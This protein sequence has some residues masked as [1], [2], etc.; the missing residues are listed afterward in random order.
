MLSL[1]RSSLLPP[2]VLSKH[3][4]TI[5][6]SLNKWWKPSTSLFCSHEINS[7]ELTLV[8]ESC[9]TQVNFQQVFSFGRLHYIVFLSLSLSIHCAF[10]EVIN[11][12]LRG[13]GYDS[14]NVSPTNDTPSR[15]TTWLIHWCALDLFYSL[16]QKSYI[17]HDLRFASSLWC[18]ITS[19]TRLKQNTQQSVTSLCSAGTFIFSGEIGSPFW[20]GLGCFCGCVLSTNSSCFWLIYVVYLNGFLLH[21]N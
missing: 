12:I 6:Y 7:T 17:Q 20:C 16:Q 21:R 8:S 4:N 15:K 3:H 1:P 9:A 19:D 2:R 10:D 5:F 11:L 13:N 18:E 14:M